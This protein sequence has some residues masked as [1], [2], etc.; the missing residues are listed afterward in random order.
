MILPFPTWLRDYDRR[1]LGADVVAG[2]TTAAVVLPKAMAYATIAGLP[3]QVGL[4]TAFVPGIVYALLGGSRVLSTSTTTTLAILTASALTESLPGADAARLVAG[5]ATLAMLVG[6]ILV[7]AGILRLGF[8]A[9]FISEPVLAGFKAGIGLVIVVDQ[10]PKLLGLHVVKIGFLRELG[11]VLANLG[12][13]SLPTVL[14]SVA[15][16]ALLV[17]LH[18]WLPRVPASLVVVALGVAA[19]AALGLPAHGVK[20]IGAIPAG[21]PS[22]VLPDLDL[23]RILWP[24]AIGI[25]LMSFTE[26]IAAGRAFVAHGE[27][28]PAANRELLA[29]GIANAAGG[30]LGAMPAGGGTSQTA[31]NEQAGARTQLAGLVT[32]LAAVATLLFLSPAL[33]LLPQ[34]VL[35]AIVVFYSVELVS[36]AEFRAIARVRRMELVWSIAAF[37]GVVLLGTLEGI[38][39]A[40]VMSLVALAQ[41][42]NHPPVY[43]V[44]RK[45]GTNVFR[46]R[47]DRHPEDESIPGLLLLRVEGRIYFGNAERVM[48]LMAPLVQ[49][50]NPRVIV[51][52][53][54]AIADLEYSALK[55]LSDMEERV[56]AAGAEL[57]VA[58]LN[59]EV[60]AVV[61]R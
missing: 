8:V 15:A 11:S 42:A 60:R 48:D 10:L 9:N 7:V 45:P 38:T 3:V 13:T 39:V 35:A 6:G 17:L 31:V 21:L 61:K 22:P 12:K 28:R 24:A 53:C 14:V 23:V 44:G 43:V 52:D 5:V 58:A 34:A 54:S 47:T 46:Q 33:A 49:A 37:G 25:A 4:C 30:A 1:W 19:T 41:Q 18:R 51:L 26:T 2:L 20:V 27:H 16:A 56:R 55:M 57:W 40:V 59:P 29:T 32:G 36:L 50:S